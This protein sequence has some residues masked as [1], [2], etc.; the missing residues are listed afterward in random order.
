MT[1]TVPAPETLTIDELI[2][3][4][5]SVATERVAK[6]SERYPDRRMRDQALEAMTREE[7]IAL[8]WANGMSLEDCCRWAEFYRHE[9]PLI[10]GEFAFHMVNSPEVCDRCEARG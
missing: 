2:E 7:R 10:N 6:L 9:V 8:F 3:R 1:V 4:L 5:D